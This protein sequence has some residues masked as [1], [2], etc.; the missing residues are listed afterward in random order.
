MRASRS[1]VPG[2]RSPLRADRPCADPM[3]A[4]DPMADRMDRVP[5]REPPD[6]EADHTV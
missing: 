1:T 6:D 4:S 5:P 2:F 3:P